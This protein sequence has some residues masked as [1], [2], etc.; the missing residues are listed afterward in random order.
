M[1][2]S[3]TEINPDYSAMSKHAGQLLVRSDV[4][5]VY[6]LVEELIMKGRCPEKPSNLRGRVLVLILVLEL[7]RVGSR[8]QLFLRTSKYNLFLPSQ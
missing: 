5:S 3:R 8:Y 4:V 7:V 6:W 1:P 2:V